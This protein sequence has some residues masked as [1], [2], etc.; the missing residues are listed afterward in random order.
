LNEDDISIQIRDPAGNPRS[1]LKQNLSEVHREKRSLMPSYASRLSPAEIAVLVRYLRSLRGSVE[2]GTRSREIS[3]LTTATAWLTRVNRDSQERPEML[4]D[5]LDIVPGSTVVDLGAGAGYFTWR[6]AQRVGPHGHVIA[7]DVQREML[8][9]IG[10]ELKKRNLANVDLVL[11]EA[12]DPRLPA[13]AV[14][15][16]LIANAYH[17][18]SDPEAIM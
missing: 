5:A 14:D 3:P 16:V 12:R 4:L 7:V 1:F 13:A 11:G 2:P 18:F 8:D 17:E 15:L 6:L 9:R 10:A